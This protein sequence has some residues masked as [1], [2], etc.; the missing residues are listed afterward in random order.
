MERVFE[1]G[2]TCPH[3]GMESDA[4]RVCSWCGKSLVGEAAPTEDRER[5]TQEAADV[6]ATSAKPQVGAGRGRHRGAAADMM[7]AEAAKEQR[8]KWPH[9]LAVV[10]SLAFVVLGWSAISLR[11]TIQPPKEPKQWQSVS[12]EN[13]YLRLQVPGN[14]DVATGGSRGSLDYVLIKSGKSCFIRIKGT[15]AL[16]A[17][18]DANVGSRSED[19]SATPFEETRMGEFHAKF[20]AWVMEEDSNYQEDA[21]Q[22]CT[23]TGTRAA[24]STYTTVRRAGV[25]PVNV[26]GWRVT[27]ASIGPFA[28]SIRA[29]CPEKHWDSFKEIA[30]KVI[31]SAVRGT[32]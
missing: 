10:A 6:E 13:D 32:S 28:Y 9:Y 31:S 24:Y 7:A 16:G 19:L 25:F 20:G 8:A 23:F 30:I 5:P 27:T 22:P 21:M 18:A 11:G 3:C 14:W 2:K 1:M 15:Q 26:K 29:E 12:S 17:M 4:Q